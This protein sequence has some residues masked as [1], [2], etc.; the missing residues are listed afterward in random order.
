M[1]RIESKWRNE[2]MRR[3]ADEAYLWIWGNPIGRIRVD[4][5]RI[6]VIE[7]DVEE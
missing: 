7:S 5:Y 1:I 2:D 4:E 6:K 3:F